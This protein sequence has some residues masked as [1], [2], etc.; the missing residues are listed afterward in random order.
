M[1]LLSEVLSP[2]PQ[3]TSYTSELKRKLEV[4]SANSSP[5]KCPAFGS[6]SVVHTAPIPEPHP[7]CKVSNTHYSHS[8]AH[9]EV[10]IKTSIL[11]FPNELLHQIIAFLNIN[12]LTTCT[13]VSILFREISGPYFL[14]TVKF[15]PS[16]YWLAVG[17]GNH[18]VLLVWRCLKSF[19][20]PLNF[21]FNANKDAHLLALDIF[22]WT[23]QPTNTLFFFLSCT[24]N[25]ISSSLMTVMKSMAI[26]GCHHISFS[27]SCIA[28]L[29][30]FHVRFPRTLSPLSS[31]LEVFWVSTH[32][33]FSPSIIPF[34]IG[35]LCYSP[36]RH[37]SL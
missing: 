12:G 17:Q 15:K 11:M 32:L 21:F 6:C 30:H 10:Q 36:L 37:L 31:K 8:P 34:M 7:V 26:S 24:G 22:L 2:C 13:K 27:Y 4:D 35:V 19:I 1:H 25:I 33:A 9:L 16:K 29:N 28:P 18:K 20:P 5:S 14:A 3:I 23:L